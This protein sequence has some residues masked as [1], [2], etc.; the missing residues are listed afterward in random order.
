MFC[1]PR[2][3]LLSTG[4]ELVELGQVPDE[5]RGGGMFRGKTMDGDRAGALITNL[6]SGY[7]T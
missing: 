6:S 7:L 3:A 5:S 1:L 4:D 2:V